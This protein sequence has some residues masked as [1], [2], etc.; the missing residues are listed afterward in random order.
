ME[1]K[2]IIAKMNPE[3]AAVIQAEVDRLTD[4]VAKATEAKTA[5]ETDLSKAKEDLEAANGDLATAKSELDTLKAASTTFDEEETLKAMPE[6][7]R[8][9]FLKMKTQKEAAEEAVRKSKE[10]EAAATAVAKALE[11]KSLPVEQAKLVGILKGASKELI[12][13]LTDINAAITEGVLNEVGKNRQSNQP[14]GG[15][16]WGKIEAKAEEIAKTK[17]IT[18]AKAI[19]QVINE[20]PDLYKEYLKGGAN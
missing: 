7:A 2:D 6:A 5:V 20:N 1:F 15:D 17:G 16:A 12:D 10:D 8:E 3:H 13:A 18:K 14:G 11:L 4:E 19:T 9:A